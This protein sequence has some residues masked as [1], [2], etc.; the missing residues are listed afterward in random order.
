MTGS[1]AG[2]QA[3]AE[4]AVLLPALLILLLLVVQVGVVARD[5]V[6]IHHVAREAARQAAVEPDRRA[7]AARAEAVSVAIDPDRLRVGLIGGRSRG[8]LLAVE[9]DYRSPTVVPVVGALIGDIELSA[10]AVV[11]VE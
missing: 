1:D 9:V 5:Y 6:A 8:D 3:T 11:A 4:L 7:V 10:R 2:G